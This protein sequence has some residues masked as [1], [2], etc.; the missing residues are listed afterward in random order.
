MRSGLPALAVIGGVASFGASGLSVA[1]LGIGLP[2]VL[3]S[4]LGAACTGL[5]IYV[6][7]RWTAQRVP[8]PDSEHRVHQLEQRSADL[9][10]ELR[11]V[12]SPA[13]MVSDRLLKNDDPAIQRAGQAVVRSIERATELIVQNKKDTGGPAAPRPPPE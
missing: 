1:L 6:A 10:H 8:A 11:G 12:L 5:L 3:A 7:G 9:R 2:F 4:L 13:M